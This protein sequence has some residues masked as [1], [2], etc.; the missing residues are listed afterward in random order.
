MLKIDTRPFFRVRKAW[1]GHKTKLE[2]L[3]SFFESSYSWRL[4]EPGQ[5]RVRGD[6]R[7][8][9]MRYAWYLAWNN[10]T[11]ASVKEEEATNLF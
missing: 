8:L 7:L 2:R 3:V 1:E 11:F 9:K 5:V 6:S 10:V 4:A